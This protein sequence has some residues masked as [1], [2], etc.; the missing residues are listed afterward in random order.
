MDTKN[1]AWLRIS[2]EGSAPSLPWIFNRNHYY[3]LEIMGI[4]GAM[5]S[6]I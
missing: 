5:P 3:A 6:K 4:D 2:M 1:G